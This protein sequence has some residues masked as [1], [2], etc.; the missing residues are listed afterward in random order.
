MIEQLNS[1]QSVL[2]F[3]GKDNYVSLGKKLEFKIE[4]EITL[5]AWVYSQIIF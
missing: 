5:E 2:A 1:L 3:N 4:K